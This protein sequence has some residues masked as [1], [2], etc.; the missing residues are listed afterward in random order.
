[1]HTKSKYQSYLLR[2]WLVEE[3]GNR[4]W[5]A[6]LEVTQSG[7]KHGFA[8]LESMFVFLKEQ[9]RGSETGAVEP[10]RSFNG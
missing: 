2:L 6:S 3:N 7:E 10:Q 1:V 5:R 9:T 4:V 8:T